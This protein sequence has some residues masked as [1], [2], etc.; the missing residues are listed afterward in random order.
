MKLLRY[1]K[2]MGGVWYMRSSHTHLF[3]WRAWV[4]IIP[5]TAIFAAVFLPIC[6]M[7]D[8]ARRISESLEDWMDKPSPKINRIA[9]W[10]CEKREEEWDAANERLTRGRVTFGPVIRADGKREVGGD[11]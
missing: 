10:A 11:D 4:S 3:N 9:K 1:F 2:R 6:A 7:L 8:V 5:I